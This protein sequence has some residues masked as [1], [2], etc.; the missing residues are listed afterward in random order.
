M[1]VIGSKDRWVTT[2][3][4]V[5]ALR[6][7]TS[8]GG[9]LAATFAAYVGLVVCA[10]APTWVGVGVAAAA[11]ALLE[12][13][14]ARRAAFVLWALR[15]VQFATM[16]RALFAGA[17]LVLFAARTMPQLADWTLVSVG[18]IAI[19]GALAAGAEQVV[20]FLRNPPV[21]T[22]NLAVEVPDVPRALP[23]LLRRP[24]ELTAAT[25]AIIAFGLA[26]AVG[27]EHSSAVAGIALALA[28]AAALAVPGCL[29]GHI[30]TLHRRRVRA[31]VREA[32]ERA[33]D[34]LAPKAALY[35][36]SDAA[37]RY[38]LEM[39][40]PV[41]ETVRPPVIVVVRDLETFRLLAPTTLPVI[42]A[43]RATA[44]MQLPLPSL[45]AALYVANTA[46]NV[47]FLR[48]PNL[49][50]V[51]IGHGDSDKSA[52]FNPITRVYSEIWVAGAAGRDRYRHAGLDVADTAFVQVGRPQL[53]DLPR[54]PDDEPMLTVLYAP[55]WE[56][57]GENPSDSSLVDV[58]P[59]LVR[60][61]LARPGVRVMYRPHPRSGHRDPA[62]RR[63]HAEIV[64]MLRVA[65]AREH[66]TPATQPASAAR[67]HPDALQEMLAGQ[68]R[69][70]PS[71]STAAYEEWT[72]L[73][74]R[75]HPT[76]R[77]LTAPAP[78]LLSCFTHTDVLIA[79]ISSVVTD[80][81]AADRPYAIV[82]PGY[83]GE[84][85]F[86]L[87]TPSATGGFVLSRTLDGLDE[88]LRAGAGEPDPTAVPRKAA[89]LYLLGP[90]PPDAME[91]FRA[92]FDRLT[93]RER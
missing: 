43:P 47:H 75:Q 27:A 59:A 28:A 37:W 32:I 82:N 54:A 31:R 5:P 18:V 88:L 17:A 56:G 71:A 73:Y 1:S 83:H 81:L 63:A 80:F 12:L 66:T 87:A 84:A 90:R 25:V 67:A 10:A 36:G 69:T 49:R 74:W 19:A 9:L 53:S 77:I 45:R 34:E 23:R 85:E 41:M 51:F 57:W 29:A 52:S 68:S 24:A 55:T 6:S 91:A 3:E 26:A 8:S 4:Y 15:R 58:G 42:C 40:L 46:T 39:W 70:D 79:D 20:E 35:Y 30:A 89:A 64:R 11:V 65:G 93:P 48:R 72:E 21:L 92:A 86:R 38:Q 50:S 76:H 7:R 78:D 61:L 60:E 22:R 2:T 13:A 33:L 44:L 62:M 16:T 14:L